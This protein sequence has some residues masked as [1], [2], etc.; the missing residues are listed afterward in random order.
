MS[1]Q[2][3]IGLIGLAACANHISKY[4]RQ[5]WPQQRYSLLQLGRARWGWPLCQNGS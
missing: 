3:D 1:A 5:S 2:C 4:R